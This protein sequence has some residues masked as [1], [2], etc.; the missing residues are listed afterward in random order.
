MGSI[1]AE[2]DMHVVMYRIMAY[3]YW[4]M[5]EGV[6]PDPAQYRPGERMRIPQSYWDIIVM[7]LVENGC[8]RGFVATPTNSGVLI[9]DDHP[10][11]TMA[12]V[13]FLQENSMMRK[14]LRVLKGAK[15]TIPFI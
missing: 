7:E 2:N 10:T 5:R 4:C 1:V 6:E 14:A 13:Q 15:G 3:L 9:A 12:G 8:V 11:V